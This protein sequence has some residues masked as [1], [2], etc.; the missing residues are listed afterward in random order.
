MEKWTHQL[1]PSPPSFLEIRKFVFSRSKIENL[2]IFCFHS[3]IFKKFHR[4]PTLLPPP[5]ALPPPPRARESAVASQ[6]PPHPHPPPL[7]MGVRGN[8][9]TS[10]FLCEFSRVELTEWVPKGFPRSPPKTPPKET[11]CTVPYTSSLKE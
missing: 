8:N 7:C 5:S 11:R 3:S 10:N 9:I 2:V 1:P 6:P 4:G